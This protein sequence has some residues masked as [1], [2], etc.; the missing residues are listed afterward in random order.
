MA[1]QH[2]TP[3]I[4]PSEKNRSIFTLLKETL[5]VRQLLIA[6]VIAISITIIFYY[7]LG[8]EGAASLGDAFGLAGAILSGLALIGVAA[9][10]HQMKDS[11]GQQEAQLQSQQEQISR[12]GDIARALMDPIVVARIEIVDD[13]AYFLVIE[14]M[15]KQ[16]AYDLRFELHPANGIYPGKDKGVDLGGMNFIMNGLPVMAPSQKIASYIAEGG[17]MGNM[18]DKGENFVRQFSLSITY[19]LKY[20]TAP[21]ET[22]EDRRRYEYS[23]NFDAYDSTFR[24][25]NEV[26]YELYRIKELLEKTLEGPEKSKHLRV[27]VKD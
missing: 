8:P 5:F 12:L 17:S 21:I 26:A 27:S 22:R 11:Q 3:P 13:T 20:S 14:N 10:L 24:H 23:F 18:R 2:E 1:V 16:P 25:R 7:W 4:A 6:A 15:G 9:S 19:S